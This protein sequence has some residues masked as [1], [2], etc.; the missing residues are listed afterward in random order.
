MVAS[1]AGQDHAPGWYH[2]LLAM[3]EGS[4]EIGGVTTPVQA[5]VVPAAERD[6][7]WPKLDAIFNGY[8]KYRA[9]TTREIPLVRLRATSP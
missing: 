2:N 9:K 1:N 5:S 8:A 6:E 7:L 3:P 4:V